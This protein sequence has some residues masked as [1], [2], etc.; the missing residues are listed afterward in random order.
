MAHIDLSGRALA[1]ADLRDADL[2]FATLTETVLAGAQLSA[3]DLGCAAFSG[4]LG[5]WK[6]AN[7]RGVNALSR[8]IRDG[9]LAKYGPGWPAIVGLTTDD[10]LRISRAPSSCTR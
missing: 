6:G 4:S 9:L 3:V 2:R 8:E 5:D 7:L 1:N 10:A